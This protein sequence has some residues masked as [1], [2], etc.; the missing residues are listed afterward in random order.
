MLYLIVFN[1]S[2]RC[3]AL[4]NRLA[5]WLR[6]SS[7]PSPY[8]LFVLFASSD[9]TLQDNPMMTKYPK[10]Q[11]CRQPE[12]APPLIFGLRPSKGTV[13]NEN[14]RANLREYV[15][16]GVRRCRRARDAAFLFSN[17]PY[18]PSRPSRCSSLIRVSISPGMSLFS[19]EIRTN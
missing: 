17:S 6:L 12:R 19:S 3:G 11:I 5:H 10:S 15:L 9:G 1:R 4:L 2:S 7:R 8:F 16:L 13:A 18:L 14:L